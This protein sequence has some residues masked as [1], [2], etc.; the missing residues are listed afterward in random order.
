VADLFTLEEL[1]TYM[2]VDSLPT[3]IATMARDLATGEIRRYIGTGR[4]AAL[5]ADE[6]LDMKGIALQVAKRV[7]FNP[8]AL[9][10]EKIDD[11]EYVISAEN[12]VPPALTDGEA[13]RLDRILDRAGAFSVKP[14]AP[15]PYCLPNPNYRS[16]V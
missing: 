16:P 13:K 5:T 3:D 4:Y 7:V 6:M 2:Q 14:A 1:V 8:E 10:S 15:Q 11:Y 12:L 9:R